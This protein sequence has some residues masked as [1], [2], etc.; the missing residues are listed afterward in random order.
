MTLAIIAIDSRSRSTAIRKATT[1]SGT[2]ASSSAVSPDEMCLSASATNP[3][4][5]RHSTPH[6]IVV[7]AFARS[8]RIEC[9]R[10]A[11]TASTVA[12]TNTYRTPPLATVG[13][14]WRTVSLMPR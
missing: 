11:I 4:T 10:S 8:I 6:S 2:D 9:L 12:P 14:P 1:A 5:P 13:N 7:S 3:N